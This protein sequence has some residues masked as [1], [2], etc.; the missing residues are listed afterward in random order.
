MTSLQLKRSHSDASS[1]D[2]S[3]SCSALHPPCHLPRPPRHGPNDG[4]ALSCRKGRRSHQKQAHASEPLNIYSGPQ[5]PAVKV[6]QP[7]GLPPGEGGGVEGDQKTMDLSVVLSASLSPFFPTPPRSMSPSLSP[8]AQAGGGLR[9]KNFCRQYIFLRCVFQDLH[10]K[11]RFY[12]LLLLLMM[13]R[14]CSPPSITLCCRRRLH[15]HL[16]RR[17]KLT[18]NRHQCGNHRQDLLSPPLAT[19]GGGVVVVFICFRTRREMMN[20]ADTKLTS[21]SR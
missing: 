8:S 3:S 2:P 14:I 17:H 15:H 7:S 5:V 13:I 21:L 6:K 10:I 16:H 20:V 4:V 9:R 1:C 12:P 11:C 18:L 19:N